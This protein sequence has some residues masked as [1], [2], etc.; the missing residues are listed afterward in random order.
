MA[1]LES[2]SCTSYQPPLVHFLAAIAVDYPVILY[3][4][5]LAFHRYCYFAPIARTS[6]ARKDSTAKRT[7]AVVEKKW[8]KRSRQR[9]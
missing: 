2:H 1:E 5:P 4:M 7:A 3:P 9:T 6:E 8:K